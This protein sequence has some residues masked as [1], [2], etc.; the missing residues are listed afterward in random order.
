VQHLC[1]DTN[2]SY[3]RATTASP[4]AGPVSGGGQGLQG[5]GQTKVVESDGVEKKGVTRAAVSAGSEG[6]FG[7]QRAAPA[8][9]QQS[10]P[11]DNDGQFAL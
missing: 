3:E 10:E 8:G 7:V 4:A 1:F 2:G 5:V 6:A 11:A 9:N